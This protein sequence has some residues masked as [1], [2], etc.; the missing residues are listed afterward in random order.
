M[1]IL[2]LIMY[3]VILYII[4]KILG[5]EYTTELGGLVGL[6]VIIFYTAIYVILFCLYPDWNWI[7][8]FKSMSI[9]NI[10]L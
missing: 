4:Y 9:K 5:E 3:F 10:K 2:D 8:I 1:H 6:A 7:D